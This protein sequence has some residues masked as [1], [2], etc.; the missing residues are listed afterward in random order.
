MANNG[1]VTIPN[2]AAIYGASAGVTQVTI[3]EMPTLPGTP[4][5]THVTSLTLAAG[6]S[7]DLDS[8]AITVGLTARLIAVVVSGTVA[9]EA[10]LKTVADAVEDDVITARNAFGGTE[11]LAIPNGNFVT[12]LGTVAVGLDAFRISITNCDVNVSGDVA[13]TFFW[14]EE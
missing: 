11:P 7:V 6:A 10:T 12:V 1:I 9:F 4:R 2:Y 5:R 13:A 8:D 14:V 3:D